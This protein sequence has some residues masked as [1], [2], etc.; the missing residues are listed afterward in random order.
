M[1]KVENAV[2]KY[3]LD[4]EKYKNGQAT[5]VVALLDKANKEISQYIKLTGGVYTKARYKE[6]ARK[7]KE[8]SSALKEKVESGIDIDGIIEYELKKQEKVLGLAS[9]YIQKKGDAKIDFL[10]PSKDQIKT[11]CL[12]KPIDTK[13]GMT[14]QSFLN[15]IE[16]GLYNTWDSAVRTGYLTGL[17]TNQIV[18]N[19]MGSVSKVSQLIN[20]GSMHTLRNSVYANTRTALQSFANETR[21]RVYEENE[22]YFGDED[23]Y[24][25][26]YLA[27]IDNRACIICGSCDCK[28]YKSLKDAPQLPQ[29]K[30]CRCIIIPYFD[31]EG[32]VKASKNGYIST[33]VTF[34]DWLGEQDEKTQIDVLGKTRYNLFKN[35][36]S[37]NQFVDNGQVLTLAQ[38]QKTLDFDYE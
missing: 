28:L 24:K 34:E 19:V 27:T 22:K 37:I 23:D 30:N 38:L 8:I 10:F 36:I 20:A 6:I 4:L 17:T 9:A 1:N 13:Y 35:G 15:G 12:F 32:D 5:E 14:Y 18:H 26:E 31:I 7:L 33:K 16:T 11:A 25:Y 29:H 2:I 3:Q 21:N